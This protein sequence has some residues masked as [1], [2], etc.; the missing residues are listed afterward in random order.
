[1]EMYEV[2]SPARGVVKAI[3]KSRGEAVK[4]LETVVQ[5]EEKP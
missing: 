2:R 1:M 3:L 5:L 4:N